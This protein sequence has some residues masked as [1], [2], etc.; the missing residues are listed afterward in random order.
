VFGAFLLSLMLGILGNTI[1]ESSMDT[2]IFSILFLVGLILF[3][4]LLIKAKRAAFLFFLIYAFEWLFLPILAY[5]YAIQH[6][7]DGSGGIGA[8][9]GL[10]LILYLLI[11]I[12]MGGFIVFFV[13]ALLSF[14]KSR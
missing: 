3:S 14:R 2:A 9:I 13:L 8:A 7:G 12:G 11:L 6:S 1:A 4:I 5:I 10:G